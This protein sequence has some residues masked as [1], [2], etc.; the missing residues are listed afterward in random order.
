[1]F[2]LCF[3]LT[4]YIIQIL[5]F[6]SPDSLLNA[7]QKWY[8]E[9]NTFWTD[10]K[11]NPKCFKV[12][13]PFILVGTKMDLRNDPEAQKKA[14]DE[15][16]SFVTKEMGEKVAKNIHAVAYVECSARTQENLSA[17][18]DTVLREGLKMKE[19]LKKK[20]DCIIM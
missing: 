7:E 4:K 14:T 13:M 8:K 11:K 9:I 18:F 20:G 12:P 15:G 16:K 6:F 3:D 2:L 1:M 19:S 5:L 10:E 17:V